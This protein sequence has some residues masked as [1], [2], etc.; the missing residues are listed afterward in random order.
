MSRPF[1][2]DVPVVVPG[3]VSALDAPQQSTLSDSFG[4]D[5]IE[6][7][8]VSRS[9]DALHHSA[10]SDSFGT[11]AIKAV[12][13]GAA[14][15][16]AHLGTLSLVVPRGLRNTPPCRL[17]IQDHSSALFFLMPVFA[18]CLIPDRPKV[19]AAS[20]ATHISA[21]VLGHLQKL[22]YDANGLN[23]TLAADSAPLSS[24]GMGHGTVI[25][26]GNTITASP[27]VSVAVSSHQGAKPVN[28]LWTSKTLPPS[29]ETL[30]AES[31]ATQI[32]DTPTSPA[33]TQTAPTLW[34]SPPSA[35]SLDAT[36]LDTPGTMIPIDTSGS[37]V[38]AITQPSAQPFD[39]GGSRY[40]PA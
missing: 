11:D 38:S 31:R 7:G 3:R 24:V 30:P 6:A 27:M 40:S 10:L 29:R 1:A 25:W 19:G 22:A 36:P 2:P 28:T 32:D 20:C 39:A 17:H 9:L 15:P 5:A 37:A 18:F 4:A 34:D 23:P 16:F 26:L 8:G 13:V 33:R 14:F 12:A 35:A 21:G